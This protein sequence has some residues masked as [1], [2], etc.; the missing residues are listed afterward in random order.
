MKKKRTKNILAG[1]QS[2]FKNIQVQ[3]VSK[4]PERKREEKLDDKNHSKH[5]KHKKDKK[6]KKDKKDKKEKKGKKESE[7][8]EENPEEVKIVV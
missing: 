4:E 7:K 1:L 3:I 6:S 8:T 2:E 5:K